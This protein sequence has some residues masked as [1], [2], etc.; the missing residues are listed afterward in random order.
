MEGAG[1]SV[2]F[3]GKFRYSMIV[4]DDRNDPSDKLVKIKRGGAIVSPPADHGKNSKFLNKMIIDHKNVIFCNSFQIFFF[5][6]CD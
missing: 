4:I 5:L 1:L 3:L 2:F 6:Y